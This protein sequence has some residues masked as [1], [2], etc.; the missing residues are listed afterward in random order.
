MAAAAAEVAVAARGLYSLREPEGGGGIASGSRSRQEAG[1]G[2]GGGGPG[3]GGAERGDAT[4]ARAGRGPPRGAAPTG[5]GTE[6]GASGGGGR[7]PG[8]LASR[9]L[10]L[11]PGASPLT[12]EGPA[13]PRPGPHIPTRPG[14]LRDPALSPLLPF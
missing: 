8:R 4:A 11:E 3:R 1:G 9:S 14:R 10:P 6:G 7:E 5:A 13:L 12:W 2:P